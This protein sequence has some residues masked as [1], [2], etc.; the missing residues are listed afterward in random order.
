MAEPVITH[1]DPDPSLLAPLLDATRYNAWNAETYSNP[2]WPGN[3]LSKRT[4]IYGDG[5]IARMSDPVTFAVDPSE[6]NL[7]RRLAAEAGE[8]AEGLEVPG[9]TGL[10]YFGSFYNV[11]REGVPAPGRI[12]AELIRARFGSA[13]F[14]LAEMEIE[15][16]DE[17]GLWW[18]QEEEDG[19]PDA[20][21]M[22]RWKDLIRWFRDHPEFVDSAYVRIGDNL[23]NSDIPASDLPAD[24]ETVGVIMPRLIVGLTRLGSLAGLSGCAVLA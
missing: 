8:A 23:E 10:N 1:F 16:L 18:L 6:L 15:P 12:E 13:L 17:A 7:C 3:I 2:D 20:P 4:V 24:V 14:A 19:D 11:A 21:N 22:Q 9:G 5:T